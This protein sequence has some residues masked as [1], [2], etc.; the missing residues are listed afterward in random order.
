MRGVS[1]EPQIVRV[2]RAKETLST[3][4][5]GPLRLVLAFAL[6][7]GA[8][9]SR[10]RCSLFFADADSEAEA[11]QSVDVSSSASGERCTTEGLLQHQ[12][13][14]EGADAERKEKRAIEI[15]VDSDDEATAD[16]VG[17]DRAGQITAAGERR[18][19]SSA[20][21]RALEMS[22][23]GL[24]ALS[25]QSPGVSGTDEDEAL[26]A[27]RREEASDASADTQTRAADVRREIRDPR[28][29][30]QE[31]KENEERKKNGDEETKEKEAVETHTLDEKEKE[32]ILQSLFVDFDEDEDPQHDACTVGRLLLLHSRL[33]LEIV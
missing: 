7:L 1:V 13:P 25:D 10:S 17:P 2:R 15:A 30:E 6:S 18:E 24:H 16:D 29:E 9:G 31:E 11:L 12:S 22:P 8:E 19:R 20:E 27:E 21:D 3:F 23:G 32:A 33:W 26:L 14:A 28:E 4:S 5:V